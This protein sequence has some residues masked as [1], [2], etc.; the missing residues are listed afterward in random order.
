MVHSLQRFWYLIKNSRHCFRSLVV[1]P[2]P[3][4][5]QSIVDKVAEVRINPLVGLQPLEVLASLVQNLHGHLLLRPL[6]PIAED[7][8]EDY[9]LPR[10]TNKNHEIHLLPFSDFAGLFCWSSRDERDAMG[11]LYHKL[12]Q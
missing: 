5:I 7:A 12:P 2:P 3:P 6:R 1:S 8:P 10:P 4:A 11:S 9:E